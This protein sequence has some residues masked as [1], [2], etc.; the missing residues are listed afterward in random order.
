M[1]KNIAAI[2]I[3]SNSFHLIIACFDEENKIKIITKEKQTLRLNFNGKSNNIP[4]KTISKAVKVLKNFQNLAIK[5]NAQIKAVATSAVREAKNK[6]EFLRQVYN[7]TGIRID[8]IDGKTEAKLIYLGIRK[9]LKLKNKN[10]LCIDIGGGSTEIIIARNEKIKYIDSLKL[11]A[12]RLAKIYFKNKIIT[13][14]SILKCK[15]HI[16]QEINKI[17][18][19]F[20]K[21]EFDIAVGT[22]GTINSVA[23]IKQAENGKIVKRDELN[24]FGFTADDLQKIKIKILS[25]KTPE[26]RKLIHGMEKKRADIIPAGILILAE[27]FKSLKLNYMVISNFALKEGIVIKYLTK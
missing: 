3:G 25:S 8:V 19:N 2:D 5:Y 22:S 12:V 16:K 13:E 9:A 6:N 21:H 15:K 17:I 11:G 24:G 27:L 1:N 7:N 14:E 23:I 20:K 4:T 18:S 26:E 10:V